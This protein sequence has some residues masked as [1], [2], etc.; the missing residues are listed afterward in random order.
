MMNASL[1]NATAYDDLV[2]DA[3]KQPSSSIPKPHVFSANQELFQY[4][5]DYTVADDECP[6]FAVGIYGDWGIGKTF[7]I[8][9]WLKYRHLSH[10]YLSLFGISSLD[11]IE[12]AIF[13]TEHPI[14]SS[15]AMK[16]SLE[17]ASV[18]SKNQIAQKFP[19]LLATLT[20]EVKNLTNNLQ[21]QSAGVPP[22]PCGRP[23]LIFDDVER[24]SLPYPILFGYLSTLLQCRGYKI[25]LLYNRNKL[26][27]ICNKQLKELNKD[28]TFFQSFG[29][30]FQ[31]AVGIEFAFQ[32]DFEDAL[33][34]I[35]T[36]HSEL[37]DQ[38]L[39]K[40][41]VRTN[42]NNLRQVKQALW[43]FK[44]RWPAA[45]QLPV[46]LSLEQ[47]RSV[48]SLYLAAHCAH[49]QL[50]AKQISSF[51]ERLA[52]GKNSNFYDQFAADIP[53]DFDCPL[54]PILIATLVDSKTP[55]VELCQQITEFLQA[56]QED[57]PAWRTLMN[58]HFISEAQLDKAVATILSRLKS[59]T[60][61]EVGELLHV[62]GL[63]DTLKNHF[64]ITED[65]R[66]EIHELV[67][68]QLQRV[69]DKN[70]EELTL[71]TNADLGFTSWKG[72]ALPDTTRILNLR[73]RY[74][75]LLQAQRTADLAKE[76]SSPSPDLNRIRELIQQ[77][78]PP[79]SQA[80]CE[81]NT[82]NFVRLLSQWDACAENT[83]FVEFFLKEM[84]H[85]NLDAKTFLDH[86]LTQI[87]SPSEP[88]F[89]LGRFHLMENHLKRTLSKLYPHNRTEPE[90]Q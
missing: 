89:A 23:L 82:A 39:F 31:K 72:Y 37:L 9:K 69:F 51:A 66:L 64:Y 60:H 38:K 68:D 79:L 48:F 41:I 61:L 84:R 90:A 50:S 77:K 54:S 1:I 86:V 35:F 71:L 7:F 57:M 21:Q 52:T 8:Q 10:C 20:D 34:T 3:A 14:L 17:V 45:D 13:K 88:G 53:P 58:C 33:Q 36:H 47:K 18:F 65:T 5:E 78:K 73:K 46:Q 29:D 74:Q 67:D 4:L 70:P 80:L 25:V 19:K 16:A 11:E 43:Q 75:D 12:E 28:K 2:S 81:Q 42:G 76:L 30:L 27:N 24:T 87:T 40:S 6:E 55:R 26:A 44:Y 62:D 56:A 63:A 22:S 15:P 83:A 49:P 32:G 85:Q 59:T